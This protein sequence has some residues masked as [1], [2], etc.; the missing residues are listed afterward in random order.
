MAC[1]LCRGK[2]SW[3]VEGNQLQRGETEQRSF[4]LVGCGERR[5]NDRDRK[6]VVL[7]DCP[8]EGMRGP[9][10]ETALFGVGFAMPF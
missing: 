3:L 10:V 5:R 4:E 6:M 2:G 7:R 8:R 1:V 9:V